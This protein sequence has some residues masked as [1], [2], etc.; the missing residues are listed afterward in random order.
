MNRYLKPF[1]VSHCI[2]AA[3]VGTSLWSG[4][5]IAQDAATELDPIVSSLLVRDA[6][7]DL[8][9][10]DAPAPAD[11]EL[12]AN[13]LKIALEL[14]PTN[15]EIA[16]SIVEAA[17]LGGDAEMLIEATREVIRIDPKDTVAQLRLVSSIINKQQTVEGRLAAFER[18]LGDRGQSL[19]PS[20]RSRLALDAALLERETGNTTGFLERLHLATKLDVS[21]KAAASL[22]A[23]VYSSAD[24]DPVTQLDYQFKLLLADPLDAN[25]HLTITQIL[26]RQGAYQ[27]A[28][29]FLENSTTLFKLDA[30]RTPQSIE[31]I[32]I[33]LD[34]QVHGPQRILDDLNPVLADLRAEAKAKIEA[35]EEAQLPTEDLIRPEDY[36]YDIG[37][38][39][40]RLLAAYNLGNSDLVREVLDDIE[41][42]T[43]DE[44]VSLSE[45]TRMR[46]VDQSAVISVMVSRVLDFQVLRAIVGLDSDKIRNDVG[47]I[48]ESAPALDPYFA[49]IEPLALFAEG[50]YQQSID[51]A[52]EFSNTSLMGLVSAMSHER[53]GQIDEAVALYSK[54]THENALDSYGAFSRSKLVSLGHENLIVTT[55]GRQMIQIEKSIP[56]WIDQMNIRPSSFMYLDIQAPESVVSA[57]ENPT[58]KI[59]LKNLAPIPLAIGSSKPLDSQMLLLPV[60]DARVKGVQGEMQ[61][62]VIAMDHRL[63]L[64][65]L[66]EL[67]IEVE[68]DSAQ[69]QWLL[70]MQSSSSITQRWRLLQGF[71]PRASDELLAKANIPDNASVYGII[72]S[73]LG[74]TTESKVTQRLSLLEMSA[75][76]PELIDMLSNENADVRTRAIMAC[77]GRLTLPTEETVIEGDELDSLI[78]AIIELYT[79]SGNTER[80]Q[81][82]LL[83]PHRHQLA[84]MIAFDDHVVSSIL[85][86]A[87]IDSVVDPTVLAAALLTRTDAEDSPIFEVLEQTNDERLHTIARIIHARLVTSQPTYSL[88][89]PG[90]DEML[91]SKEGFGF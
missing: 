77:A 87:L 65:P 11:Y 3:L 91:P 57:M 58:I 42:T 36:R 10:R 24:S 76:V 50:E 7:L 8:G 49:I 66:E 56:S 90:V 51:L 86:G 34:W 22:A 5:T 6:V 60:V 28:I 68:T 26:A 74:L 45:M 85:S 69:T 1:R 41:S 12:T 38:D 44:V 25:V 29:R 71:R 31:E 27:S 75:S 23:Q 2:A 4:S 9:L 16:R 88:V 13:L 40:L 21:N 82:I 55:A 15:P 19:D 47:E 89:G 37:I 79:I 84:Q 17:W 64:R 67:V 73:P 48:I 32:R 39:R 72:N 33:A 54:I 18:F 62:K 53:L 61:P 46:S 52:K 81:M 78:T 30:G 35:Y 83:L 63:R 20:V 59:R 80:A 70:H 43:N 14:D